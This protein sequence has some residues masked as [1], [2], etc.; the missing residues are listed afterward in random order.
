MLPINWGTESLEFFYLPRRKNIRYELW[1]TIVYWMNVLLFSVNKMIILLVV[2]EWLDRN[3]VGFIYFDSNVRWW[4][5]WNDVECLVFRLH[6][7]ALLLWIFLGSACV[8]LSSR[9]YIVLRVLFLA[10]PS[11]PLCHNHCTSRFA[12]IWK[13]NLI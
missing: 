3:L 5:Y 6:F 1:M 9:L 10:L 8:P 7:S 12:E 13:W 4:N 11:S 2:I